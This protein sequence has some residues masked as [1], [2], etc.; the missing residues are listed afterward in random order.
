MPKFLLLSLWIGFSFL[1]LPIL[2]LIAYSFNASRRGSV[3]GGFSTQWYGAL[4]RDEQI[5]GAAWISLKIGIYSATGATVLG[6][7]AAVAL[8]RFGRFP[9]RGLFTGMVSAPLVM[10]EVI[11]GISMLLL[12][13]AAEQ[14]IGWPAGRGMLTITI[15]HI[16]FCTAFVI[17]VVQPRLAGMDQSLEEASRDLGAG[18]ATTFF[19]IT[20]PVIAP[21]LV[22]G[23]L[24]A[25][26]LSFDDLVIVSFT[27]GPGSTTLPMLIFSKIKIAV[28]PDVNALATLIILGVAL[29]LAGSLILLRRGAPDDG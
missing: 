21:A 1:Y 24:L 19:L 20:L 13:I 26:I 29:A 9:G 12:F 10:P 22:S 7:M 16:T 8:V 25:F 6:V 14:I 11:T 23:W 15:A 4:F 28:S 5:L 17:V 3:W 2:V 27:A 18:P